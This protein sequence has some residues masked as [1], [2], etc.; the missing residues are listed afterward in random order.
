LRRIH[1]KLRLRVPQSQQET[2]ARVHSFFA[3]KCPVYR[4]LKDAIAITTELVLEA[5]G[6]ASEPW[7]A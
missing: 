1:F 3:E 2:A 7:P 5:G 6:T 4:S